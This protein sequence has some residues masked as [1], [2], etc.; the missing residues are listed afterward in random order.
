MTGNEVRALLVK[1]A[2]SCTK[3]SQYFNDVPVPQRVIVRRAGRRASCAEITTQILSFSETHSPLSEASFAPA[4]ESSK[5]KSTTDAESV[6]ASEC[7]A[8]SRIPRRSPFR[9]SGT[10]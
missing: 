1:L 9:P 2:V 7:G 10:D 6:R 5:V 4:A 8:D 3:S